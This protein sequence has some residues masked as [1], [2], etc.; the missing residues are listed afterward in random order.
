M[1][2]ATAER[3]ALRVAL[4]PLGDL[5]RLANRAAQRIANVYGAG[6]ADP[7]AFAA[8]AEPLL[9]QNL[10]RI[11]AA[12]ARSESARRDAEEVRAEIQQRMS[13]FGGVRRS[14]EGVSAALN[15][16]HHLL[17]E[18][19]RDGM[20]VESRRDYPKLLRYEAMCLAHVAYLTAIKALITRGSGS[21]GSHLVLHPEGVAAHPALGAGWRF[22]PENPSL[23]QEILEVV[24][25]EDGEFHTRVV[26]VRPIPEEEFW[27]ENTW[28]DYRTGQVFR[29]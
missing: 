28:E 14:L 13:D 24:L 19:R 17:A 7:G 5:E 18:I 26:P 15:A 23:R 11:R 27:F 1:R 2:S 25:G 9:R 21:R 3:L 29:R 6:T 22:L 8:A 12:L 20:R 16:A 4:K 10:Q